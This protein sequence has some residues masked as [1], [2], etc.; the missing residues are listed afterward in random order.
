MKNKTKE[1]KSWVRFLW[2]IPIFM[3]IAAAIPKF[4]GVETMILEA[5]RMGIVHTLLPSGFIEIACAIVFLIPSTR[6]IG[7]FLCVAYIGGIIATRWIVQEFNMGIPMQIL[8]WVGMYFEDKALF[9][10]GSLS[11]KETVDA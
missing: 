3:L 7:F 2:A 4:I 8:L 5:E 9:S 10:I 1:K 11:Q 6:R